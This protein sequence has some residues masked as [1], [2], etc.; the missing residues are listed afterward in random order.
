M[1]QDIRAHSTSSGSLLLTTP[2][3]SLPSSHRIGSGAWSVHRE[4]ARLEDRS[5][6]GKLCGSLGQRRGSGDSED[7]KQ[8]PLPGHILKMKAARLGDW[9]GGQR[10]SPLEEA[11]LQP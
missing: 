6:V 3:S 8:A 2:S 10:R 7:E 1:Q 4:G 5:P 11:L 9:P